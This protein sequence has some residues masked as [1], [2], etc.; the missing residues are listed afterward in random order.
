MEYVKWVLIA[1]AAYL[2][3]KWLSGA[4]QSFN[5]QSYP[6]GWGSGMVYAPG[7]AWTQQS[8]PYGDPWGSEPPQPTEYRFGG[9][10]PIY[11]RPAPWI[12]GVNYSPDTGLSFQ[13]SNY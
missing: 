7:S 8:Y 2:G 9:N 4:A 10:V 12:G 13:A 11:G 3:F 6:A 1:V 5:Q